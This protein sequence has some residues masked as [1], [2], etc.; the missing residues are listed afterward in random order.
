MAHPSGLVPKLP[1]TNAWAPR[2][3]NFARRLFHLKYLE[4]RLLG[5][6]QTD[7]EFA[8]KNMPFHYSR[9]LGR[10]LINMTFWYFP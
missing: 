8:V 2:H 9:Y 7:K 1:F 10:D 3:D 5:P 4:Q 6:E